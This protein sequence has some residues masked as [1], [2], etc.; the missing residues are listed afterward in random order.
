MAPDD[1]DSSDGFCSTGNVQDS[2]MKESIES[3]GPK[4]E[5]YEAGPS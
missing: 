4:A 5:V 1:K 3:I 2:S